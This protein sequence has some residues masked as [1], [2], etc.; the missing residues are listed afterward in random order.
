MGFLMINTNPQRHA[1]E[2]NATLIYMTLAMDT[3]SK[4]RLAFLYP[5]STHEEI[6]DA[7]SFGRVNL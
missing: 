1:K 7:A 4:F 2:L 5:P 6:E 3:N